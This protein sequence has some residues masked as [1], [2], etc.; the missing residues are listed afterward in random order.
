[1]T[2]P[3][4]DTPGTSGRRA[5]LWLFSVVFLPGSNTPAY[6]ARAPKPGT[7]ACCRFRLLACSCTSLQRFACGQPACFGPG[8]DAIPPRAVLLSV[9]RPYVAVAVLVLLFV[10]CTLPAALPHVACA[11]LVSTPSTSGHGDASQ[12]RA[13]AAGD[14]LARLRR[15]CRP[16]SI[17]ARGRGSLGPHGATRRLTGEPPW[18]QRTVCGSARARTCIIVVPCGPDATLQSRDVVAVFSGLVRHTPRHTRPL[19]LSLSAFLARS[20]RALRKESWRGRE[21]TPLT[22]HERQSVLGLRRVYTR[23][24]Q[25]T[26]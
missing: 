9:A 24:A 3:T 8:S 17:A 10:P 25:P 19:S 11:Y 18:D 13:K 1:M 12:A 21:V 5:S 20:A 26:L 4:T 6:A 15:V 23:F 14:E 16:Q 22:I 7:H 2:R